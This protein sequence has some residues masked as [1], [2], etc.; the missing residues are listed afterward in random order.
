MD[1]ANIEGEPIHPLFNIF[2]NQQKLLESKANLEEV[3]K[4]TERKRQKIISVSNRIDQLRPILL[5]IIKQPGY[6]KEEIA[7][8]LEATRSILQEANDI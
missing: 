8:L 6:P 5:N 3:V 7:S 1:N 4:I 2:L